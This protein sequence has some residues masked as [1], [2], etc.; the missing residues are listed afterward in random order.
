MRVSRCFPR[1]TVPATGW[2]DRS[3]R[4]WAGTRKSVL[5]STSPVR[6]SSSRRAVRQTVSPSGTEP[7]PAWGRDEAGLEQRLAQRVASS[8][9]VL[10][11]GALDRQPAE[12][13]AAHRGGELLRGGGERLDVGG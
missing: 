5:V 10:A 8:E 6:V 11:V 1:A 7:Q 9:D 3:S 13:T 4:A 2:P 12:R